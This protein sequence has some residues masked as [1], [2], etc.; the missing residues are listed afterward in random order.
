VLRTLVKSAVNAL[1]LLLAL[2][3]AAI[4]GFGRVEPLLTIFAHAFALVPGLPGDFLRVAFY[5]LTLLEC[6]LASR[7]SFG[8]FCA[9]RETRIARGVYIGPYC[10]LGKANIGERTQLASGVQILSGGRQ[11]ERD[12]E[13]RIL[14][15]T[16]GEFTPV[17]LGADCW[18]GAASVVMADVGARSTI[19]AGSVVS[20]AIPADSV[21]VGIPAR[22]IKSTE[23]RDEFPLYKEQ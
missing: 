2:P 17:N 4:S 19:G 7:I 16:H 9:H 10:V 6:S 22:V 1:C 13:G 3:A 11:H 23:A 21:A 14:G 5:K 8:A 15:S 18:I 12:A 20:R